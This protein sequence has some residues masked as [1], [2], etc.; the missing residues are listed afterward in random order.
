MNMELQEFL[1]KVADLFE[2]T[3]ASEITAET[4][5]KEL[6][7]WSSLEAL[8]LIS[9]ADEDF[10]VQ[11]KNSDLRELETFKDVYDFIESKK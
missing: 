11:I 3:D 7:E 10:G 2:D 4:K 6:D 9:M 8:C 1:S 5:F